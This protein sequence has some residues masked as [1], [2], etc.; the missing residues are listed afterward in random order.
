MTDEQPTLADRLEAGG[1][2]K[3][4]EV[5]GALA[6][7]A[8]GDELVFFPSEEAHTCLRC[9]EHVLRQIA[10]PVGLHVPQRDPPVAEIVDPFPGDGRFWPHGE[11]RPQALL[12]RQ[13]PWQ[14]V[15]QIVAE[16]NWLGVVVSRDVSYVEDHHTPPRR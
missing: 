8:M 10:A 16:R 11:R 3:V 2:K 7:H 15:G 6:K 13:N 14:N 5:L 9:T 4:C 1:L 12:A